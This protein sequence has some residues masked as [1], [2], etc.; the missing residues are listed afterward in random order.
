MKKIERFIVYGTL[1]ALFAIVA[2]FDFKITQNVYNG[3]NAI[4]RIIEAGAEVPLFILG[5]FAL[6]LIGRNHPTVSKKWV[7][8]ALTV[9]FCLVA[10][11]LAVYAGRHTTKL[12]NRVMGDPNKIKTTLG[13]IGLGLVYFA[14]GA[15]LTY[16]VK[17]EQSRQAFLFGIFVVSVFAIDVLLMQAL[18]MIW[19]RPRYRTLVAMQEVG[20]ISD[21]S[22]YW[23]P[24]THPQFFTSFKN[25]QVGSVLGGHTITQDE[26]TA[27]MAKLG[28]A[29]WEAEEFYSFPS[30]HTMNF[31]GLLTLTYLPAIFPKLQT[32]K[33]FGLI[34]R[35]CVYVV[36]AVVA[37]SRILRGAHNATDV[38]FA[39]LL[40]VIVYD[41]VSNFLYKDYLLRKFGPKE[42]EPHAEEAAA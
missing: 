40:S 27:V 16:L 12:L 32:K 36:G 20:I 15:G 25:Y 7:N 35:I 38:L 24:F 2:F 3:S 30:G 33:N 6:V 28:V 8:I 18:K 1:V 11:G 14:G 29:K 41:V 17:K 4:G 5:I 10:A 19:L 21:V 39:F 22:A 26:I 37:F 34:F 31:V 9:G 23:L 13:M 42:E